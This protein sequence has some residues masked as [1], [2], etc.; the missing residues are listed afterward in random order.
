MPANQKV[1][2]EIKREKYDIFRQD[3]RSKAMVPPFSDNG[4]LRGAGLFADLAYDEPGETI[5]IRVRDVPKGETYDSFFHKI[6]A[7]LQ[8]ITV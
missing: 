2:N 8:A 6:E 5:S 7:M 1:F 4:Y 3:L